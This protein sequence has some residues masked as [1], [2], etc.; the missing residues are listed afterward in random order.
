MNSPTSQILSAALTVFAASGALV[1]AREPA[2][3]PSASHPTPTSSTSLSTPPTPAAAKV[4]RV[5]SIY[6]GAEPQDRMAKA[7]AF[8]NGVG[9]N[10]EVTI[11]A[12]KDTADIVML[13][14]RALPE[15][16]V[17]RTGVRCTSTPCRPTERGVI[18]MSAQAGYPRQLALIHEIGH[19]MGLAHYRGS[20]CAVMAPD[21]RSC[22]RKV[23]DRV[24]AGDR[25]ALIQAWGNAPNA[26]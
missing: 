5:F 21:A 19:A 11:T 1:L 12:D 16:T 26:G 20:G 17:G 10:V 4:D 9:A 18:T 15:G 2:K 13:P 6:P 8:W 24:P 7:V 25:D 3:P 22:D 14:D 23:P